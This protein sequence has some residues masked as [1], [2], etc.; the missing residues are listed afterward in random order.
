M[1]RSLGSQ[2]SKAWPGTAGESQRLGLVVH[3]LVG[4]VGKLV[5]KLLGALLGYLAVG[6]LDLL[7][8]LVG[9]AG[10]VKLAG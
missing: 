6:W 9:E 10:W 8:G 5:G 4:L 2:S 3:G 1:K 7:H